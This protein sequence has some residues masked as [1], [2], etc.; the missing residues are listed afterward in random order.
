M[1]AAA[2]RVWL[3]GA[4]PGDPRLITVRG[5]EALRSADVVIADRLVSSELLAEVRGGSEIIDAGKAP[6][7]HRMT[8]DEIN[9]ELVRLAL[10][11]KRV[12]RLKGGDPFIYGRGWEELEACRA[13]GVACEV[14]P[15]ITSALAG[16][17]AAGVPVTVRGEARTLG[18]LT[19]STGASGDLDPR[20][21]R[22]LAR[23]D[24]LSVLMGRGPLRAFAASLIEAGKPGETPAAVVQDATLASQRVAV[25]TLSTIA[26]EADRLGLR[27]P[28][29][30]VVGP[31]ARY[32]EASR[33]DLPLT[34]KTIVVTRPV[35]A[36]RRLTEKLRARG[37][38]V[39]EAPL[40]RI[41][42]REPEVWHE[43]A[44]FS[45]VVFTSLHGV[46][47]FRRQLERRG[48]D[49][50][51]FGCAKVAAVGPKTASALRDLGVKADLVPD[52]HRAKALVAE[53]SKRIGP[54][55][56]VLFPSGTLAMDALPDGL[57]AAGV[58]VAPLK[59]YDTLAG[60]IDGALRERVAAG[61][62]AILLYSPTAARALADARMEVGPAKIGVIG[63]TTG[64]AARAAGLAV[65]FEAGVYSD[66]GMMEALEQSVGC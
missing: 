30:V 39:I 4:G 48:L 17:T 1:S 16:P 50:R 53:L 19:P 24:T 47:G 15:G 62:D 54:G 36:S 52:E 22:A 34:G 23:L 11:G 56:R 14:I 27:A 26:D 55:G 3:I 40:I 60:E 7:R 25:G 10:A 64:D 45:W 44:A 63:P 51:C 13:A 2:G 28:V 29:I 38:E 46:E 61:V 41:E 20:E 49:A 18:V 57:R 8:Q 66:E 65:H 58:E 43:P 21:I 59:V 5:L 35:T 6:G 33:E 31:V 32:A 42:Y 12:A 9:A 37:A